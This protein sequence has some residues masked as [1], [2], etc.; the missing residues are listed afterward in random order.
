[1]KS[2][3]LAYVLAQNGFPIPAQYAQLIELDGIYTHF[4]H[5]ED[6]TL[7]EGS[8]LDE[9]RRIKE[10]FQKAT[11][12]TLIIIDEPIRG[13]SPEDAKEMSIRFIKGFLKLKAPTFFTT[14]LHDVAR[15]VENWD[16]VKNLQTK[17]ELVG[18]N[19]KPT[20]KIVPG[21]SDKSYG[22]EIAE[23]FGL[24]EEDILHM[25]QEKMLKY[26]LKNLY[27]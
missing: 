10:L 25:I 27:V 8:Y 2:I 19:I 9:L 4:I 3:G 24:S 6:I 17:V 20:Y 22:I 11:P 13:T 15:K 5:P 12:R 14:H 26:S 1:V 21:K 18:K 7:G 16:G 23:K